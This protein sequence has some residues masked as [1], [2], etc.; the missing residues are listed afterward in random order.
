MDETVRQW[1]RRLSSRMGARTNAWS[2]CFGLSPE[3][4]SEAGDQPRCSQQP[5]TASP[6]PWG[7]TTYPT[8][9]LWFSNYTCNLLLSCFKVLAHINPNDIFPLLC[10]NLPL[11]LPITLKS[12]KPM[13]LY[14]FEG[15]R[16]HVFSV[17]KP[18]LLRVIMKRLSTFLKFVI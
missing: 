8:K 6:Q 4:V 7:R 9:H 2:C 15:W 5:P 16:V 1:G 17:A 10:F 13:T 3:E 14:L 18:L 12:P 11:V